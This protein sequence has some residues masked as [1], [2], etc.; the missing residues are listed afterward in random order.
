MNEGK[1][2]L[3]AEDHNVTRRNVG[4]VLR[5]EGYNVVLAQDGEEALTQAL[6]KLPELVLTNLHM[7]RLN[8][9]DV[10]ARMQQVAPE[11]PL[12]LMTG[13]LT[14]Q[15]LRRSQHVGVREVIMKPFDLEDVLKR[16]ALA[17]RTL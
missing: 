5:N 3:I 12:F 14:P 17:L 16:I 2:I 9:L 7:P 8:G 13:M 1:T 6:K 11:I 10:A 4:F 15:I